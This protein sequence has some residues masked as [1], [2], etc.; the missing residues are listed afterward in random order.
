MTSL[1]VVGGSVISG[2]ITISGAKNSVLPII[3]A[4]LLAEQSVILDN[5]PCLDDVN[6]MCDLLKE[7]GVSVI[8]EGK[9]VLALNAAAVGKTEAPYDLVKNMRASILV[10]GPLLARFGHAEVSFPGGC[11]I[12]VR[13]VD[14]HLEA[15]RALGA[16]ISV[17]NGFILAKVDGR[18]KGCDIHFDSVT[19]TGTENIMMAACLAE[20]RTVIH[21]AAKEPEVIDLADFL[22][23][24]GASIQGDGTDTIVIDGVSSLKKPGRYRI[25]PD[26]IEAGTYLAAA[27]ITSGSVRLNGVNPSHL[28]AVLSLLEQAGADIQ[29]GDTWIS[30]DM[31]GK[32]P[33]AVS[34]KTE[35]YPGVPTDMQAQLMAMNTVAEGEGVIEEAVF[36]NRLMHVP[37]MRR[38]GADLKLVAPHTIQ[39]KGITSLT[40]APVKATDLRASAGL[41]LSALVAEGVTTISRIHHLDRG[42]ADLDEKLR[43]LGVD[44]A[45]VSDESADS[46]SLSVERA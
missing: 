31:H 2:E 10:L 44:V 4:T 43:A 22:R 23:H 12:G 9:G 37:E 5:V 27:V 26:R 11:A 19:V 33:K 39:S 28:T 3:S 42:Y 34:F 8:S 1:R 16:D 41:V 30:L 24:L 6:T 13:P 14:L 25:I 20:G 36:E 32:R 35:I 45:R 17:K 21:N 18:L 38:L 15:L 46:S 7:L 40:A 29:L